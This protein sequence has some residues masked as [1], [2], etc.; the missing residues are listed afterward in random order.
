LKRLPVCEKAA[1]ED[2]PGTQ[3]ATYKGMKRGNSNKGGKKERGKFL[4]K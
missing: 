2:K 3:K 1:S 4:E